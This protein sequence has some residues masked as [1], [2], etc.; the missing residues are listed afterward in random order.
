MEKIYVPD[1]YKSDV[2]YVTTCDNSFNTNLHTWEEY[3]L[4]FKQVGVLQNL[5]PILQ[6]VTYESFQSKDVTFSLSELQATIL[7][8]THYFLLSHKVSNQIIGFAFI[9][10]PYNT[11]FA[12]KFCY[13]NKIAISSAFQGQHFASQ[14]RKLLLGKGF[15]WLCARTQN[16]AIMHNF[17]VNSIKTFPFENFY[18][19]TVDGKIVLE[20]ILQNIPQVIDSAKYD[21]SKFDKQ[22]GI[23]KGLY[24]HPLGNNYQN[25]CNKFKPEADLLHYWQFSPKQGDAILVTSYFNLNK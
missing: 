20:F 17:S 25:K 11:L 21:E 23:F 4:D 14:F 10:S 18:T 8:S 15:T 12:G 3:P 24:G 9:N 22:T 1:E 19:A 16:P 5:Q 6:K 13:I 2:T 7:Q